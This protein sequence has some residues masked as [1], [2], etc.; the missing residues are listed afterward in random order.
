[1]AWPMLP[2]RSSTT[3][4]RD[5]DGPG[6]RVAPLGQRWFGCTEDCDRGASRRRAQREFAARPLRERVAGGVRTSNTSP[7]AAWLPSKVTVS[8][9][10]R[11]PANVTVPLTGTAAGDQFAA[12]AQL[13]PVPAVEDQIAAAGSKAAALYR[14][15]ADAPK[16]ILSTSLLTGS[17]TNSSK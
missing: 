10:R 8:G 4:S 9:T 11:S 5:A 12:L 2:E 16:G 1:M 15:P 13:P 14:I 6:F 7:V 3:P 17:Y